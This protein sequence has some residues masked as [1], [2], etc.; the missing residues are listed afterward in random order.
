MVGRV[1]SWLNVIHGS[2]SDHAEDGYPSKDQSESEPASRRPSVQP[3]SGD[4]APMGDQ[5]YDIPDEFRS[6]HWQQ[7]R[8]LGS[9]GTENLLNDSNTIKKEVVSS[10]VLENPLRSEFLP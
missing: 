5:G 8:V 1:S 7:D 2:G 9:N 6:Y 10:G 4:L 3:M